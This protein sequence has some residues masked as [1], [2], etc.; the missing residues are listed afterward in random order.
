MSLKAFHIF[1]IFCSIVLVL[2]LGVWQYNAY[3]VSRQTMAL[4]Y[5]AASFIATVGLA[6]YWIWFLK[7]AKEKK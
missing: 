3:A 1:F 2:G 5:A 7:K 4:F 6:A